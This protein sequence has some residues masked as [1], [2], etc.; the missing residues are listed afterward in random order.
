[1]RGDRAGQIASPFERHPQFVGEPAGVGWTAGEGLGVGGRRRR[2]PAL[3][4]MGLAQP[5]QR[6]GG[7]RAGRTRRRR[8][9]GRLGGLEIVVSERGQAAVVA[10]VIAEQ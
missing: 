8:S 5:H 6:L 4:F 9:E 7:D 10:D 1:M 2:I 3:P